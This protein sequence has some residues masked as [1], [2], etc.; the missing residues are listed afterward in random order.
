MYNYT[1]FHGSAL[2]RLIQDPRTHGIEL[3]HENHCYLVNKKASIYLKHSTK[4]IS[5]WYFTFLPEH[6]NEITTVEGEIKAF[7]LVLI[8]NNDGICCL[9]Y[10]EIAQLI[11]VGNM[12]QAKSIRVSRSTR[13]KYTVSGSDGKLKYKIG[14]NVFPQKVLESSRSPS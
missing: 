9:D 8:C 4:R 14:N 1:F 7:F 10:Q 5:P 3:Y 6:L 12:D 2:V 11:L 13:E